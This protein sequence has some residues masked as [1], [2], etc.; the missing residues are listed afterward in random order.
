MGRCKAS[1]GRYE[2]V[3]GGETA[4]VSSL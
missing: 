3:E 1:L 4:T 2:L